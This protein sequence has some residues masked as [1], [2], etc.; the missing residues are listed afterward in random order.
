MRVLGTGKGRST[1]PGAQ[2]TRTALFC[3]FQSEVG[4][5]EFTSRVMHRRGTHESW[6]VK[7]RGAGGHGAWRGHEIPRMLSV[8]GA[9]SPVAGAPVA[10]ITR[11]D[12]RASAWRAFARDAEIVDE[13][14]HSSDGLLSVV[15]IGE[16]PILRLGT[17]SLWRDLESMKAFAR[18]RPEH[19]RVVART[20]NER[21]YGEEMFAR[22]TPY[23]SAGSWDGNDPLRG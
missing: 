21:W 5:D 3:V 10:M 8:G 13:E 19:T 4:A 18:N 7:M 20:R 23:W 11:A 14:L 17:F 6:H 22:F 9:A 1:A 16:A 15:G 12:V 2:L